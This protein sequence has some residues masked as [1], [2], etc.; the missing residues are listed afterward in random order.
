[1]DRVTARRILTRAS[2]SGLIWLY[3]REGLFFWEGV[4][5]QLSG[6]PESVIPRP[7]NPLITDLTRA[8]NGDSFKVENGYFEGFEIPEHYTFTIDSSSR[9]LRIVDIAMTAE[10][11]GPLLSAIEKLRCYSISAAF[12][13]AGDPAEALRWANKP[14][15]GFSNSQPEPITSVEPLSPP[16]VPRKITYLPKGKHSSSSSGAQNHDT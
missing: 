2:S 1:V 13:A 10:V 3:T 9:F 15:H 16:P 7:T 14:V 8:L 6:L 11:T 5:R 4:Y 12:L